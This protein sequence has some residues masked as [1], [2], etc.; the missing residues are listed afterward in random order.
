MRLDE[1]QQTLRRSLALA[2]T[3]RELNHTARTDVARCVDKSHL[4][5]RAVT[6]IKPQN[7]MSGK[8]R[9]QE[10]L[11]EIVSEYGNRFLFSGLSQLGAEFAFQCGNEQTLVAVLNRRVQLVRKDRWAC[12]NT[13]VD[14]FDIG[15]VVD[16]NAD[17]ET[18]FFLAAI[19]CENAM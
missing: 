8:R 9:L 15:I 6:R 1:P 5:A 4:A 2:V 19:D 17:G 7:R 12:I 3:P 10:E 16:D 18:A 14:P 11:T 13:L